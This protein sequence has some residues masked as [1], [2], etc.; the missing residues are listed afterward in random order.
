MKYWSC[1][2]RKTTEFDV[3]LAQEGCETGEHNWFRKGEKVVKANNC[4]NDYHQ[5]T[6]TLTLNFYA[7]LC[8]PSK[9]R[10][11]ASGTELDVH[12]EY[13][14]GNAVYDRRIQL[15]GDV[16]PSQSSVKLGAKCEIV[17][18]K[19][20]KMAWPRLEYS[21]PAPPVQNDDED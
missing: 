20:Q 3:F 8:D 4:R 17:L 16:D 10:L 15:F 9:C 11:R 21:P 13:E 18:H 1:C 6:N 14:N 7:K 19:L 5:M 2:Q 12:L